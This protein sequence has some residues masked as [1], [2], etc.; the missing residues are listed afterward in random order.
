[1]KTPCSLFPGLLGCEQAFLCPYS[2]SCSR[3][4]CPLGLPGNGGLYSKSGARTNLP[5]VVSFHVFG[6]RE[7][8]S[9]QYFPLLY[10]ASPSPKEGI[11]GYLP[12]IRVFRKSSLILDFPLSQK[13]WKFRCCAGNSRS[14]RAEANA[15]GQ[16][17]F[18]SSFALCFVHISVVHQTNQL[19]GNVF[20]SAR[21][22]SL[23][24]RTLQHLVVC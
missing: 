7:D 3:S 13:S 11:S 2:H 17:L 16:V 15:L 12:A 9:H 4:A 21:M 18:F 20:S 23:S 8:K 24:Q 19:P 14:R 22:C 1:M 10:I 6:Q 5:D